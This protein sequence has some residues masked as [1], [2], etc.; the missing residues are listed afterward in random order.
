[1]LIKNVNSTLL[2]NT[3]NIIRSLLQIKDNV[4]HYSCVVY[5]GNRSCGENHVG[6]SVR[7]FVLRWAE[8]EDPNK[9]SEPAK[10]L[11]YFPEHQFEWNVLNR[12]PVYTRKKKILEAFLI[13]SIDPSLNEQ[14]DTELLVLFRNGVT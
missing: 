11:K 5:E 4:K 13:K 10:H 12:V 3:R 8:Y 9:L 6:E 14:L 1:M 2:G 7:N